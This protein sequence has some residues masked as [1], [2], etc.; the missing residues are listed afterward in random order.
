MVYDMCMLIYLHILLLIYKRS[1]MHK[2]FISNTVSVKQTVIII[3]YTFSYIYSFS[4]LFVYWPPRGPNIYLLTIM[5][6]KGEGWDP[7]KQL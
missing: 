4:Y 5:D 2:H 1:K 3:L 7:V 6:A